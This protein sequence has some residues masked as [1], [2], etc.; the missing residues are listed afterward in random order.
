LTPQ[1]LDLVCRMLG[2]A[3]RAGYVLGREDERDGKAHKDQE[4]TI[5]SVQQLLIKKE[6]NKL[7][8][9]R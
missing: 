2:A 9:K 7:Q 5:S 4:F 6:I 8:R 1:E 3:G